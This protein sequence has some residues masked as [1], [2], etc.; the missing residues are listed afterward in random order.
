MFISIV[1]IVCFFLELVY[2]AFLLRIRH[3]IFNVRIIENIPSSPIKVSIIIPFRNEETCIV[4]SLQSILKLDYDAEFLEVIYV[5][6]ASTDRSALAFK[7]YEKYTHIRLINLPEGS[8]AENRK[9]FAIQTGIDNAT[10]EI[11]LGTDAD[12][13]FGPFWVKTMISMFDLN[14]GF[15]SGPVAYSNC[16]TTFEKMQQLEFSGL[17]LSGA[18][19]IGSGNPMICNG[20]NLAYRRHLFAQVD[21]FH[22]NNNLSS[23][24]D[25]LLMKKI[26][27]QTGYKVKFCFKRDAVVNTSPSRSLEEFIQQR[28][29]WA[30]KGKYYPKNFLYFQLVPIFAL[31]VLLILLP[32]IG[33]LAGSASLLFL[34]V[35]LFGFK[36]FSEYSILKEGNELLQYHITPSLYLQ[37]AFLQP[38]YIVA[39]V[40]KG[41]SGN[42]RWKG[43]SVKK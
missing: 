43:R 24:D 9:K 36:S 7:E 35:L 2:L 8:K 28:S 38:L 5:N 25:E 16:K 31:Y 4:Q 14:T 1:A 23:G 20:A 18:G 10:G 13:A 32:L 26:F 11:I 21:G 12:C 27:K 30:S 22:D 6:D 33:I 15:V 41:Y 37:T 3:G 34:F 39:A 19:L 17:V 42:Y 40:I 29:R